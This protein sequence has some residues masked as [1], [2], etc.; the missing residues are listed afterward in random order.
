MSIF[1]D[2]ARALSQPILPSPI[3][4]ET[5]VT[6]IAAAQEAADRA[7][8]A[9]AGITANP[10]AELLAEHGIGASLTATQTSTAADLIA[11]YERSVTAQQQVPA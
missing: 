1:D 11:A 3:T 7:Q 2:T 4:Q 8:A 10:L 6:R 9:L 5:T